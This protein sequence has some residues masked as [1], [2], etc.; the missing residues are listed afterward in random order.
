[1]HQYTG[2]PQICINSG[3]SIPLMTQQFCTCTSLCSSYQQTD[4]SVSQ[5]FSRGTILL[6]SYSLSWTPASKPSLMKF[7]CFQVSLWCSLA[8]QLLQQLVQSGLFKQLLINSQTIE[9]VLNWMSVY[10]MAIQNC[11]EVFTFVKRQATSEWHL[12]PS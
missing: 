8:Y 7:S 12:L 10:M 9:C 6:T 2:K 3:Q 4:V 11:L 5:H 1:M